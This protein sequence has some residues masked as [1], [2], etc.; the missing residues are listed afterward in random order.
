MYS[1][2]KKI[3]LLDVNGDRAIRDFL[4]AVELVLLN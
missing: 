2:Y 3:K 1:D 4:L